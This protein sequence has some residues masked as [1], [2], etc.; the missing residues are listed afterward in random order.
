VWYPLKL[1]FV[2]WLALPQFKGASFIY[3]KFVREQLRKYRGRARKGDS[4]HKVHILKVTTNHINRVFSALIVI[5]KCSMPERLL[6]PVSYVPLLEK[7]LHRL[8]R[9]TMFICTEE[10]E[11]SQQIDPGV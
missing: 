3:E 8:R 5:C 6:F 11:T 1:L 10:K 2:A 4:D 9:L 7:I